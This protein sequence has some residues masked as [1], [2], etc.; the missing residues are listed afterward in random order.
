MAHFEQIVTGEDEVIG[1]KGTSATAPGQYLSS[2][3]TS[4]VNWPIVVG[5]TLDGAVVGVILVA[6]DGV[7]VQ[8]A[9]DEVHTGRKVRSS[10]A[11]SVACRMLRDIS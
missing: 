10:G 5:I 11:L 6:V 1:T 7:F 4:E 2:K 9:R 8:S 3:E